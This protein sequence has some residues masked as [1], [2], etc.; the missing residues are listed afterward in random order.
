M[1]TGRMSGVHRALTVPVLALPQAVAQ[2]QQS[3]S[4]GTLPEDR[5]PLC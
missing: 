1:L 2:L 3:Q 5:A 4:W